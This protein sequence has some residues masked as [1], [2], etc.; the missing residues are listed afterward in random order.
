[1]LLQFPWFNKHEIQADEFFLRLRFFLQRLKDLPTI[2]FVVEIRNRAW[3][4]KRLTDLLR[5]YN[6]ALALTDISRMPRPREMTKQFDVVATDFVY[7][8]LLGDRKGI[9][10]LTTTWDKTI[11][12]RT[13]D[14]QNWAELFRQFVSRN[15]K[16]Y[17]YANNHY[18][19]HGPDTVKLF[20]DIWTKK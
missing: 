7:V 6:V 1:M 15:L 8:R 17:A 19:G 20:W 18:A 10:A 14:L 13:D 5:E 9:E 3:L 16:V 11:I 4:D 12:N 2:R